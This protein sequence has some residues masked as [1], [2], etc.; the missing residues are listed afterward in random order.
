MSDESTQV[1]RNLWGG[2]IEMPQQH[3]AQIAMLGL[4]L[5]AAAWLLALLVKQVVL[6]PLFCGDPTNGACISATDTAA[7]VSAIIVAFIGL[8]GLVRLSVYR[9]LLIVL[10][11]LVSLWGIGSWTS[12]MEWY[13]SLAWFIVLY[14]L[15]YLAF[16]WLVRPRSFVPTI[17]LV[18]VGVVLVR[19]VSVFA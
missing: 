3:L 19:L 13:E 16:S 1:Q 4:A 14:T 10:A 5:G 6:E 11:V 15:C 2:L 7:N 17:I 18:V 9:P 8:L 12:G